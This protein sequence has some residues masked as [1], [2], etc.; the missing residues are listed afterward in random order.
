MNAANS[1]SELYRN[2]V[3]IEKEAFD[4]GRQKAVL[5][6]L[7]FIEA[8]CVRV[9]NEA[10]ISKELLSKFLMSYITKLRNKQKNE[11]EGAGLIQGNT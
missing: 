4:R 8:K 5:T 9:N 3:L 2:T 1:L 7:N 10:C 11:M 6:V